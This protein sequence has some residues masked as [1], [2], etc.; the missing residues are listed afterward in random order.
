VSEYKALRGTHR[1]LVIATSGSDDFPG[2]LAAYAL[3]RDV[4][5][6]LD[7]SPGATS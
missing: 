6:W 3:V 2:V 1:G 5:S 7:A 4:L